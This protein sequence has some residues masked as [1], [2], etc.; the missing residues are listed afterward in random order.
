LTDGIADLQDD[1]KN[2]LIS[3]IKDDLSKRWW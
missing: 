1:S 2:K 3:A